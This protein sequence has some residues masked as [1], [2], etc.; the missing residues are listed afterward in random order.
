M[1]DFI[2]YMLLFVSVTIGIAFLL[3]I[4]QNTKRNLVV[5]QI[6][7]SISSTTIHDQ[8]QIL[9]N[10]IKE[11]ILNG[12]YSSPQ[13]ATADLTRIFHK[14]TNHLRIAYPELTDLDMTVLLLLAI[15][16]DN[17]E[18]IV[19]LDM[20]KRTYYKRRQLTATRVGITAAQLDQFAMANIV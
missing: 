6:A 18:I 4:I 19:F 13:K 14:Q 15:G 2:I 16:L 9:V 20:S 17:H 10:N 5:E 3:T 12:G 8:Q 1:P 7:H 11:K